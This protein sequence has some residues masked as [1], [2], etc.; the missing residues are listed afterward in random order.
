[1]GRGR[2][3]KGEAGAPN[4][5]QRLKNL[6]DRV[7][8]LDVGLQEVHPDYADRILGRMH[9]LEEVTRE[10]SNKVFRV[11]TNQREACQDIVKECQAIVSQAS[12]DAD[13][14]C[15]R[16]DEAADRHQRDGAA[17][18]S[19]LGLLKEM[20]DAQSLQC[21]TDLG[22]M[23]RLAQQ[24]LD[25]LDRQAA[26]HAQTEEQ[27]SRLAQVE[28]QV[29]TVVS[30]VS[31][32]LAAPH[33]GAVSPAVDFKTE[34]QGVIQEA[35]NRPASC[36]PGIIAQAQQ[37]AR[38]REPSADA[39]AQ[40]VRESGHRRHRSYSRGRQVSISDAAFSAAVARA[41]SEAARRLGAVQ[42]EEVL[43]ALREPSHYLQQHDLQGSSS[44]RGRGD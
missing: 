40:S 5:A 24:A 42:T 9:E 8:S 15:R 21:Q 28:H 20:I 41:Q 26:F 31:E 3:G 7:E 17:L 1:M 4:I 35:R 43:A 19:E 38:S 12:T 44:Q 25:S 29:E 14:A 22:K 36:L 2:H 34:Q 32:H 18:R 37:V 10:H 33:G 27:L 6:E 11:L 23:E 39:A 13:A 16:L 30:Q